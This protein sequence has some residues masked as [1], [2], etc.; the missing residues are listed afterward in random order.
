MTHDLVLIAHAALVLYDTR[1]QLYE[2]ISS[3]LARF[4]RNRLLS[5]SSRQQR[6]TMASATPAVK[7]A[8]RTNTKT[9]HSRSYPRGVGLDFRKLAGLTLL[10]YIDHHGACVGVR[11]LV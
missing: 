4:V 7:A 10:S 2:K 11:L 9:S 3:F 1:Q 8:R 5:F 6:S